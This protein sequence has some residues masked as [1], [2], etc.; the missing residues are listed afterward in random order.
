M[1]NPMDTIRYLSEERL[2]GLNMLILQK[3]YVKKADK[4]E[5]M[6]MAKL[7]KITQD[8][9]TLKGDM[10][11]KAVLLLREI[12]QQHPFASGNRRTAFL[13]M[14][15][16]LSENGLPMRIKNQQEEAN[17]L[18]GVRERHYSDEELKEWIKHGKIRPFV[19]G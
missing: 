8:C 12:I 19:R 9:H 18:Q 10:H 14:K 6:S 13:A 1:E 11:D 4:A 2:I 16:F 17:V 7:R 5:V 3:M 15:E